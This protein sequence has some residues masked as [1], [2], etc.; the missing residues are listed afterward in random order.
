MLQKGGRMT[1]QHLCAC[2]LASCVHN[3]R[4]EVF[5]PRR[6]CKLRLNL[7]RTLR[8]Y[9]GRCPQYQPKPEMKSC[10][11]PQWYK[12]ASDAVRR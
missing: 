4:P 3:Y 2:K 6:R 8:A 7:T 12:D 10:H 9:V 1:K 5:D 11:W